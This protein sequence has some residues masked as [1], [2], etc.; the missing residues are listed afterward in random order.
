MLNIIVNDN[1]H[2][3]CSEIELASAQRFLQGK[4]EEII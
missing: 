1:V 3:L 4:D 2:I